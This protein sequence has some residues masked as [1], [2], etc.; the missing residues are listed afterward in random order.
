MSNGDRFGGL[1]TMVL[2]ALMRELCC[3]GIAVLAR[4]MGIALR[5]QSGLIAEMMWMPLVLFQGLL[6][7][8]MGT[9]VGGRI[10]KGGC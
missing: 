8:S 6:A 10:W 4:L 5:P 3:Y 2:V 9:F 7:G 1:R